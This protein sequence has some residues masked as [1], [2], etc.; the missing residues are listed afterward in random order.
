MT[1]VVIPAYNEEKSIGRVIRDL[2]ERGY[3]N[4]VVV[5]D[6][7]S[8]ATASLAREAGAKVISHPINRGQGAALQTGDDYAVFVGA[9]NVVHFDADGQFN[10]S[11]IAG[12]L[13]LMSERHLNIVLGSRFLDKRSKIPAIKRQLILP[14]ARLVNLLFTGVRLTDA[15]NGFRIM[16]KTALGKIKITQEG[17]AHNS[18]II[19]QM[20]KW[21]L[22][23]AEYPVE[24]VYHE[25]GQGFVGGV[26][27]VRDLI[28]AK[29]FK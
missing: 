2:F 29:F 8:D 12:A 4:I 7:S 21:N 27:V 16:D 6:G 10:S 5:N 1:V 3:Q 19:A 14:V 28:F 13:R 25:Y 24:V 17:M 26:R 23:F 11:D 20:K 22:S 9:E 18:E 15:H